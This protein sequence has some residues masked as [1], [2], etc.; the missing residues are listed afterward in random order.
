MRSHGP[1][2]IH[3]SQ[4]I[5]GDAW[6][7]VNLD[8]VTRPDG[9]PGTYTTVQLKH[10]V[11]VIALDEQQRVHLTR[12]FHYAVGRV[13]LEGVS[14]GIEADESPELA[15]AR[16]LAEELGLT[17]ARWT[18]LCQVDPFTAAIDSTVDLYLAQQLTEC[19]TAPEGTEQIEHVVLPLA[20]AVELVRQSQI[21]H[22]PTCVALLR[23]ALDGYKK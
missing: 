3:S 12:E 11:C 4:H 22:A 23:I 16:E 7:D 9:K 15:A 13:T 10:G 6:I 20:E 19:P 8:Q 18:R 5:Y 2:T 14:G 17:A 21:T 1:W